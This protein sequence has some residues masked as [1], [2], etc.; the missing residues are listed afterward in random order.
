[1][2]EIKIKGVVDPMPDPDKKLADEI[3]GLLQANPGKEVELDIPGQNNEEKMKNAKGL[4][5]T[6]TRLTKQQPMYRFITLKFV[7]NGADLSIR[8]IYQER[9]AAAKKPAKTPKKAANKQ[10]ADNQPQQPSNG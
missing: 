9:Q 5:V 10:Q 4:R 6:I 1:M 2:V 7:Q 8:A 3:L